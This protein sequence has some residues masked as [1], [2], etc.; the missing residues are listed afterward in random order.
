METPQTHKFIAIEGPI[1]VGKSS[2]AQKLAN[3]FECELIKENTSN[4]PFLEPFYRQAEQSALPVQLHFLTERVKL[5]QQFCQPSAFP[6]GVVT[7]F[8]L[9]KDP[10]F[11]R[12]TLS[13][14]EYKLYQ[15]MYQTLSSQT[16]SP[17]LVI[18]LQAP[19][20]VLL[21][22]IRS[23]GVAYEK[24]I[25]KQY[26]QQLCDAY[27]QFF[28]HYEQSP[29]LIVNAADIN[30]LDNDDDYQQL[31]QHIRATHSGKHFLN[32]LATTLSS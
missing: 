13:A 12:L 14:D 29:L 22:R 32:P 30:P 26:L 19:V 1:G 16:S 27:T 28:H 11:A 17:D 3:T 6:Q 24:K 20:D 23:R 31:V 4:N 7:D 25:S 8:L 5:W 18:Y 2:L 9:E 10:L 15:Q 21:K